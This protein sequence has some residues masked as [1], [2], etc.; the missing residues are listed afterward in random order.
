[1]ITRYDETYNDNVYN[2]HYLNEINFL[3]LET[4]HHYL[5]RNRIQKINQPQT[6]KTN[7]DKKQ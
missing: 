3:K 6:S 5:T 2:T 7:K 1:M 4:K